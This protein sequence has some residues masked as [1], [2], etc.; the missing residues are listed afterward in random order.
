MP[1]VRF[2]SCSISTCRMY[3]LHL[4]WRRVPRNCDSS[5]PLVTGTTLADNAG[6]QRKLT[7][8]VAGGP[9]TF[10]SMLPIQAMRAALE[11]LGVPVAISD[12]AGG[13]VCNHLFYAA[14]YV[15][16]S[17]GLSTRC[18]FVHVPLCTEQVNTDRQESGVGALP[19]AKLVEAIECCISVISA[20][21][22]DT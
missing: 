11:Q 7:P 13:Y 6:E 15:I 5:A 3:S 10:E 12:D 22:C 4:A 18:G 20:M 21:G 1:S 8:I 2:A 17:R 19:R 14:R 16:D 9:D